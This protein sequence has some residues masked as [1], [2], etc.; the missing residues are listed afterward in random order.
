MKTLGDI[1]ESAKGGQKPTHDECYYSMLVLVGLMN[2]TWSTL[3]N[4]ENPKTTSIFRQ[5]FLDEWFKRYRGALQA[6]PVKYLGVN[7]PGNPEYDEFHKL[8]LKLI[9]RFSAKK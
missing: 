4:V 1:I 3:E 6:D 2:M 8:G 9:E 5:L 7:V